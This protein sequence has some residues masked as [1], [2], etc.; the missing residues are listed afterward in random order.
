MKPAQVPPNPEFPPNSRHHHGNSAGQRLNIF[1]NHR[2]NYHYQSI[3]N[4]NGHG[5]AKE[6]PG[7]CRSINHVVVLDSERDPERGTRTDDPGSNLPS[8][9]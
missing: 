6:R 5:H 1:T 3:E 7:S 2:H 4:R 9:F 8:N